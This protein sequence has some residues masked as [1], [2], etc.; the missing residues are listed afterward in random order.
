MGRRRTWTREQLEAAV[1]ASR[2]IRGVIDRLG[3]HPAGG[4]YAYIKKYAAEYGFDT[5]HWLGQ[6]HRLGSRLPVRPAEPL[7]RLLVRD[8]FASSKLK[9]RLLKEG[10]F[11]PQCAVCGLR[12]WRGSPI[13]LDMDH[14]DGD[15]LNNELSNLRLLCPNCHAQTPTYKARNSKYPRIPLLRDIRA[16]IERCGSILAYAIELDVTPERVRGWLRSDRL[17]ARDEALKT[18]T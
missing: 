15:H 7:A 3:L 13:P 14:I 11:L 18:S 8:R 4:T 10:V 6:G 9:R 1:K 12:E 17:R 5:S 2:S 16:G